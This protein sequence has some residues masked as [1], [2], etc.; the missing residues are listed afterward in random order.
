MTCIFSNMKLNEYDPGYNPRVLTLQ[1]KWRVVW[2]MSLD[3]KKNLQDALDNLLEVCIK[4]RPFLFA[5]KTILYIC[6]QCCNMDCGI[7][8]AL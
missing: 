8:S 1:N 3:R 4:T 2:R 5:L 7:I 6:L